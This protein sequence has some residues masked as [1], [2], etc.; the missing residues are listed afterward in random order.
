MSGF[1]YLDM[2]E[3]LFRSGL[4]GLS[5]GFVEAQVGFVAG[6]QQADGGFIGQHGGS[7]LYYTDFAMRCL[8]LLSPGHAASKLAKSYADNQIHS[9]N[10]IVDC[11]SLLNLYRMLGG[12]A[13]KHLV[14][15]QLDKY[16]L[17]QG[18]VARFS[19]DRRVSAY[20]TFLGCLCFQMLDQDMPALNGAISAIE[21][22]KR[23]DGGYAE[24][25]GQNESQTNATAAAMAF[26]MM[27]D[28]VEQNKTADTIQFL[29]NMQSS[30]G[31]L[32]PHIGVEHGDLLSTFTGLVTL[33]ALDAMKYIDT[34]GVAKFLRNT[35]HSNGGFV[36]CA[37]DNSP[38]VEYTYY[39]IGALAL[40]R[41]MLQ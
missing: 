3:E 27:N 31:G 36:A 28:A 41:T 14:N 4:A 30:D 23:S 12:S 1:L 17:P 13:E 25:S 16:I 5:G 33:A 18:G 22:L 34:A 21:S 37:G 11:F 24:L 19:N 38:D 32:K 35:S 40:L 2:L 39:G 7:D 8:T 29:A 26:L 20:H 10:N 15:G 9:A 6:R